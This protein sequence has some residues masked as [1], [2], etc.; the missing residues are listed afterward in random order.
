MKRSI[1]A[2]SIAYF[3]IFLFLYT[4]GIKLTEIHTFRQQLSSSPLMASLAGIV[5]WTLPIGEILLAIALFIPKWRLKGLYVTVGLMTLFTI[6]VITILLIDDQLTCSCGG[7]I[8]ELSPKQHVLFNTICMILSG[9]GILAMRRQQPT[10]QFKWL[11]GTTAIGLFAIVGWWLFTAFQA[12]VVQKTGLEGRLIPSIPLLLTDSTTWLNTQDIP[13]GKPFIVMGFAPW[14][15]HCQRLTI[16]IK[17]HIKD[18]KDT[19]IF[20]I[21]PDWFKNMRSFYEFYK[22]SQYPNIVMG[23]DSANLFFGFFNSHTTPLITIYDAKKRLKKVIPGQ[24]TAAQLAQ[25]IDN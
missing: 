7:I 10:R 24:P 5:A 13:T 8:E 12:P 22:L 9:I 16:D 3:F 17:D 6:Y 18:F 21:T 15:V 19:R 14:C 23:R 2:D 11:T 20:Y 25:M 1:L 4:G